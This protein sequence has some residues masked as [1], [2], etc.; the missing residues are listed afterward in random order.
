MENTISISLI[1]CL[2]KKGI[3]LMLKKKRK[4]IND[5]KNNYLKIFRM[6]IK[7]MSSEL[8]FLIAP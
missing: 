7:N 1:Y 8:M 2:V 5:K 6:I 4:S 3:I